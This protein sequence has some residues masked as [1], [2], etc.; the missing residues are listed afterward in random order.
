MHRYRSDGYIIKKISLND[1]R[2]S[3]AKTWQFEENLSIPDL[4]QYIAWA[5][6]RLFLKFSTLIA[7]YVSW[8]ISCMTFLNLTNG[9]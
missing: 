1:L 9:G 5:E 6:P 3:L 2:I 4:S 8:N 7:V